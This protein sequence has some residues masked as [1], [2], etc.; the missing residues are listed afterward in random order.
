M[1]RHCASFY[2]EV[3]LTPFPCPKLKDHPLL[4]VHVCLFNKFA[5]TLH[6]R[7]SSSIRNL[8]TRHT[9]VAETH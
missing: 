5:A 6:I 9:I 7:G 2:S 4:A 3:F 1:F 8:W